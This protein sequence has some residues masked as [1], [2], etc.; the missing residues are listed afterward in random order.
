MPFMKRSAQAAGV[1]LFGAL[2]ACSS[3]NNDKQQT[4]NATDQ[5]P[6][7]R[8]VE[9]PPPAPPKEQQVA[10]TVERQPLSAEE[11]RS[12]IAG[13]SVYVGAGSSE[14]AAYHSSDGALTGKAWGTG[15]E[16]TGD[17]SWKVNDD[18][19]YCRKW[20]NA[21]SGGKWGCF[22]VYRDGEQL[23][24]E[25]VSGAGAN[26]PMKLEEGNPHEL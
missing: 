4:A 17:G 20:D 8:N 23:Q 1:M 11:L 9:A 18:G 19:Q 12:T 2:A 25:R 10:R 16:Q 22:K 26:G 21:W 13:N 7:R 14:F 24:M 15:Q 3:I 5:T 6:V